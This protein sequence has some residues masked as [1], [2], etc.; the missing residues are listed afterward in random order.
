[1]EKVNVKEK[2]N[3]FSEHWQPKIIGELNESHVKVA[4]LKG[5]FVWHSHDSEDEMF[6][7]IEGELKICF[8]EREVTL[9][10][11]EFIIVPRGVDHK[12]VAEQEVQVMLIEAKTTVNTGNIRNERTVENPEII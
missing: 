12:P 11:D 9:K 4:R 10:K 6:Y 1:M 3:Q 7:V 5:E 2:L 8:R